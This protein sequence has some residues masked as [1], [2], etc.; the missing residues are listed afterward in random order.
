MVSDLPTIRAETWH[1]IEGRIERE[2]GLAGAVSVHDEDLEVPV[3]IRREGDALA[4]RAEARLHIHGIV[5]RQP[6]L[7]RAVHVHNIDLRVAVPRGVK[8]DPSAVGTEARDLVDDG[9]ERELGL[10]GPVLVHDENLR[11]AISARREGDLAR[12]RTESRKIVP[13]PLVERK[14][15]LSCTILIHDEDFRVAVAGRVE[16][17]AAS[18]VWLERYDGTRLGD[19]EADGRG[20]E[21]DG[22]EIAEVPDVVRGDVIDEPRVLRIDPE[23]HSR[24]LPRLGSDLSEVDAELPESMAL[25]GGG[26]RKGDLQAPVGEEATESGS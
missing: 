11:V 18:S 24:E 1:Q 3:P 26:A 17:D 4:V 20:G 6:P 12:I 9:I 19:G 16:H 14:L 13:D 23:S 22:D 2:L 21:G 15:D 25:A 10:A 7:A 8:R 5:E